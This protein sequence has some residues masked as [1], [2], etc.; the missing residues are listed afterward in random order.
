MEAAANG[1]SSKDDSLSLQPGPSSSS[2]TFY[3]I[4]HKKLFELFMLR[5]RQ[6]RER[7][8]R[9]VREGQVRENR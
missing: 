4:R 8:V 2:R 3:T 5:E 7:Q 6:V 9:Q 1:L